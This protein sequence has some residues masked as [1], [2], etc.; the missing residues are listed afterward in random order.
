MVQGPSLSSFRAERTTPDWRPHLHR[1]A[2]RDDRPSSAENIRLY[3]RRNGRRRHFFIDVPRVAS[4]NG[5]VGTSFSGL[6]HLRVD[7]RTLGSAMRN[8]ANCRNN[9]STGW[10]VSN[11]LARRSVSINPLFYTRNRSLLFARTFV[12]VNESLAAS[13]SLSLSRLTKFRMQDSFS[14][15]FLGSPCASRIF[16]SSR[17]SVNRVFKFAFNVS[18]NNASFFNEYIRSCMVSNSDFLPLS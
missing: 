3:F 11:S 12:F 6:I 1:S 10:A 18:L 16:F 4:L 17:P 15:I 9:I 8:H 5:L 2:V 7:A 14:S 13:I